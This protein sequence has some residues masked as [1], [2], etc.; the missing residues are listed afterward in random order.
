MSERSYKCG[1]SSITNP[2]QPIVNWSNPNPLGPKHFLS[3]P[4]QPHIYSR[5]P[6]ISVSPS[7]CLMWGSSTLLSPPEARTTWIED[8][9]GPIFLL[10]SSH[11]PLSPEQRFFPTLGQSNSSISSRVSELITW[12]LVLL[13]YC[14]KKE[15]LS[16]HQVLSKLWS[17]P[18][19]RCPIFLRLVNFLKNFT[20]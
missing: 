6:R 12:P 16:T 8:R 2:A 5:S 4:P 18:W 1:K 3:F 9:S 11:S 10:F 7:L 17:L 14:L 13:F 15:A 19:H 20:H